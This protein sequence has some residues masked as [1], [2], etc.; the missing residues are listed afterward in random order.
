M[1][2][3]PT[4]TIYSKQR[5]PENNTSPNNTVGT[6]RVLTN[7]SAD[8]QTHI[9]IYT[10]I[11]IHNNF[12]VIQNY[13][14]NRIEITSIY[15]QSAYSYDGRYSYSDDANKDERLWYGAAVIL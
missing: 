9:Y 5:L 11:G 12:T 15:D 7:I 2:R 1:Y 13:C 4:Y 8:S 14:V 6:R 10:H 3:V